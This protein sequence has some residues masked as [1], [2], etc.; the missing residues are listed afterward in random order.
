ADAWVHALEPDQIA[1]YAIL[2][3]LLADSAR[4]HG[5]ALADLS[6]EV[7]STLPRPLA[8]VL[9]RYQLGRWRVLHKARLDDPGD[10]YR[11][12]NAQPGDWVMLG[13]HDTAPIFAVIRAWSPPQREA[14][15]RHLAARLALAHPQRL[16]AP[17]FL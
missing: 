12:E 4:R 8:D 15:S 11:S 14:W 7:L 5:R 16:A 2:F 10:V 1:L 9:A 6:C 17:H 3:D 13:N